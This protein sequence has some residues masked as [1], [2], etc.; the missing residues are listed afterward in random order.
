[1]TRTRFRSGP[2]GIPALTIA[3]FLTALVMI[4]ASGAYAAVPIQIGPDEDGDLRTGQAEIWHEEGDRKS[5]A[6]ALNALAD[7]DFRPLPGAGSSGLKKGAFWSHFS[8][9]NLSDKVVELNIEYVD[10][11]LIELTAF[12]RDTAAVDSDY[13]EL[14]DMSMQ[15]PFDERPV[16]SHRFVF[17]LT[18]QPGQTLE[19]LVRLSSN[20]IGY[21]YP[22][23][24]IWSPKNLRV[25]HTLETGVA[26]FLFGGFFVMSL[27]SLVAAISTRSRTFYAYSLYSLTKIIAWAT[28]LGFTHQYL[29]RTGFRWSY[30]S[31]AGAVSILAGLNFA[32]IFLQTR[33]HT[34]WLDK[35][36]LLMLANGGVLFFSALL[37]IK[38][39]ALLSITI[40]L[41]L[42]P[43]VTVVGV[44]RWRQGSREAALFA[45]AW[46]L[47][48]AS[49]FT[50]ALRDMGYVEHHLVNYYL[51]VVA[52]FTEMLAIMAAVGVR[53]R[54]LRQEKQQA[55]HQYRQHLESSKA[56]LE[57]LV[58]ERTRELE[59]AKQQAE[60]EARTDPL[61]G[62][63]NRRSFIADADQRI[64]FVRRKGQPFSLLMFDIDHFKTINDNHGH[65]VGDEAL[66]SFARTI[67]GKIRE[68]DIFGRIGGEEFGLLITEERA[69]TLHTAERL[70]DDIAKASLS[71]PS[72]ELQF[73][74]SIGIAHGG[75]N[76]T[77]EA[78]MQKADCALYEAK[79]RGR[80]FVVA[81]DEEQFEPEP[82]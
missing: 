56:E 42:Y 35:I 76:C 59:L 38:A 31:M 65:S 72:G 70:R 57:E 16:P 44:V 10:H 69:N 22:S 47:L 40:A 19:L 53:V 39:L 43:V 5:L 15:A 30:M 4:C 79:K 1:M 46:G 80:D 67:L 24:R 60:L 7:G 66:C 58:Y 13:R 26:A 6:E 33:R 28:I 63:R 45:V 51:P 18:L 62:I 29:I 14:A 34:I 64:K 11:Q 2:W 9:H 25:S 8:L 41:L 54:R 74:S 36:M 78:L 17:P 27:F 48:V 32:R 75:S 50:Q 73:T 68:T 71:T 20:E 37:E 21:V 81:Y 23:M 3:K 77:L 49:L 61:T 55:E 12:G 52:S 82:G